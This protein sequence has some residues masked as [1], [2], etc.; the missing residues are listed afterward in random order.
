MKLHLRIYANDWIFKKTVTVKFLQAEL[1]LSVKPILQ[2]FVPK[3]VKVR[4]L[5]LLL[6]LNPTSYPY[7]L[8]HRNLKTG[9]T[10]GFKDSYASQLT[11]KLDIW[12]VNPSLPLL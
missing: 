11:S 2:S 6:E 1:K 3:L 12:M 4:L 9:V 5:D 8:L 7:T 10:N